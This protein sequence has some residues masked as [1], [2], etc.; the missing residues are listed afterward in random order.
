MKKWNREKFKNVFAEEFS[1]EKE[2]ED[3]YKSVIQ[4]GMTEFEF[5]EEKRLN[6]EYMEVLAR[7]EIFW[8]QKSRATWLKDGDRNTKFFHSYVKVRRLRN[9][10]FSIHNNDGIEVSNQKDIQDATV[11]F[12]Q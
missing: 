7:E 12:F 9:K 4:N 3:L 5:R 10:I 1:I 6:H 8:R 2:L 11:R